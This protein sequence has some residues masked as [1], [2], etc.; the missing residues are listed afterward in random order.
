MITFILLYEIKL[1]YW[2]LLEVTLKTKYFPLTSHTI[3]IIFFQRNNKLFE[4]RMKIL[5]EHG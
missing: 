5:Y 3:K 2:N 1:N 4:V